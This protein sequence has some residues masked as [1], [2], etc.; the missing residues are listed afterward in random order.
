MLLTLLH[1]FA[2]NM[3]WLRVLSTA[4]L[5]HID[6]GVCHQLHAKMSLLQV[7]KPQE[8]PLEFILPRKV[9]STRLLN[10][11]MAAL[12]NRFRPRLVRLRLRGFS[13]ILGIMPALKMH[14]RLCVESKPASRFR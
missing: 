4:E 6:Q 7:F 11:W 2:E 3:N 8:Q 9:R 13:V 12:K 10:A 14:L 5:P 1:L